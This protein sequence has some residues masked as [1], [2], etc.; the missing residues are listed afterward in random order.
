MEG[1]H[2]D[3]AEARIRR[4][5][6][7]VDALLGGGGAAARNAAVAENR[8]VLSEEEHQ[9]ALQIKDALE[10]I[11]ELAG[12]A[13]DYLCAQLALV[14]KDDVDNAVE[15][16]EKLQAFRETYKI[17]DTWEFGRRCIRDY[18]KLWPNHILSV[19]FSPRHGAYVVVT[20]LS[21]VD[22]K[23]MQR[24]PEGMEVFLR[25]FYFLKQAVYCDLGGVR[26]GVSYVHECHCHGLGG[27]D[28]KISR[29]F[30]TNLASFYPTNVHILK[31][32]HSGVNMNLIVSMLRPFMPQSA[33]KKITVGCQHERT[34]DTLFLDPNNSEASDRAVQEQLT[35]LLQRRYDQDRTFSLE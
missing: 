27:I 24:S 12:G 33:R 21:K 25:F 31:F 15:R 10:L 1:P 7:V 34:L 2:D 19:T 11:P 20:D 26:T 23:A 30:F 4:Q 17:E 35:E 13:T 16:A 6:Q 8:M 32:F 5:E 18:Q 9:W 22:A 29:A 3:E 28:F 14:D